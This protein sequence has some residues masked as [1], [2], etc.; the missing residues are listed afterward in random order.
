MEKYKE[1]QIENEPE[2]KEKKRKIKENKNKIKNNLIIG[3]DIDDV[4]VD[5]INNFL[6]YLEL[7][8]GRSFSYDEIFNSS[9]AISLNTSVENVN[10]LIKETFLKYRLN[11]EFIKNAKESIKFLS[12]DYDLFFI[13][14]RY[15]DF[16]DDTYDFF[17][18]NFPN[19]DFRIYF[20]S[21]FWEISGESKPKEKICARLS[22][23]IM[24]E[25]NPNYAKNCAEE[26][27]KVILFD[28]PWNQDLDDKKYNNIYRVKGWEEA[29]KKIK[30]I[31]KE[32]NNSLLKE[33]IQ[34]FKKN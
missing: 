8:E 27:I 14:S 23:D 4:V 9:L 1:K 31:E 10:S 22:V 24:I 12:R 6:N 13:T 5:F 18:R 28:K 25:D 29:L 2:N 33:E 16:R 7:K 30:E 3:V 32:I 11:F 34:E 26:D 21:R 20:S 17:K 19:E 15:V